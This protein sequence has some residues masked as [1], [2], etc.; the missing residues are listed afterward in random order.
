MLIRVSSG[1]WLEE[2]TESNVQTLS[3]TE[4]STP[5]FSDEEIVRLV[6]QHGTPL[7]IID[8]ATLRNK[9]RELEESF[10]A[11]RGPARIAYSIKANF[12]PSL[13]RILIS[14]GILFDLSTLGELFFYRHSG[15]RSENVIYTS[16]T[17]EATEFEEVLNSGV[18]RIVLGSY[19]GFVNLVSILRKLNKRATVMIRIN[20][21]VG[22]KAEVRASYRHGKF[23]VPLNTSA[24]DSST[25]LVRNILAAPELDLEGFHFHLGSQ[26]EDHNCFSN[27]IE[28]LEAFIFKMKREFPE[29][30]IST[31]DIGGGTPVFY[32]SP[33]PTANEIGTL[34]ANRLNEM[35]ERIGSD[36]TVIVESGRY[37]SAESCLLL[38]KIVNTKSQGEHKTVI[39]DAGY[40]LLLDAALLRQIYPQKVVGTSPAP[41]G[42]KVHLAGKLCD[43]YDVFP[44]SPS[45]DLTGAEIGKYVAFR[46][47]GAYSIVFNMPFHSQTKP[48]IIL[49]TMEREYI[50][51][52]EAQSLGR[53]FEEEGGYLTS[54]SSFKR[55]DGKLP[56]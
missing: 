11:F 30:A 3:K 46:N 43:T 8:E 33:V 37:I 35:A 28:K 25:T 50:T 54:P 31:V 47:T 42:N 38:S 1:N 20:P 10:V 34:A 22:V 40:H 18:S 29:F 14:E 41:N 56:L 49:R 13:V 2:M 39:V 32:G 5:S 15:G 9:V 55:S 48:P 19:N 23:G 6:Q 52:R 24:S 16:V 7:Y 17:E 4:V 36:F 26:I 53:L 27:A 12:N 21:E 45:S 51:I 44:I